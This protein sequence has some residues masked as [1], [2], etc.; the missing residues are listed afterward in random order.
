MNVHKRIT[1]IPVY[2]TDWPTGTGNAIKRLLLQWWK[3]QEGDALKDHKK[4]YFPIHL[5]V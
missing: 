2:W 4:I 3:L 5:I 1:A